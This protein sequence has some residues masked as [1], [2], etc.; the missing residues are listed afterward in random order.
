MSGEQKDEISH[1]K[2]A[3]LKLKDFFETAF[4]QVK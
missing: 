1:R 4:V 3:L 2:R